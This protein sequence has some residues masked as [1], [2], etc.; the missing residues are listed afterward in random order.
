MKNYNWFFSG[1]SFFS[2][3]IG[4]LIGTSQSPVLGVFFTAIIGF[5]VALIGV[6]Q[7][8][9]KDVKNNKK[10]IDYAFIGKI[11][12]FFSIFFFIGNFSGSWYRSYIYNKV[13]NQDF[14]WNS[15]NQPTDIY[16]ALDWIRTT[17]ILKS[18]GFSLSQI[19]TLYNIEYREGELIDENTSPFYKIIYTEKE[20][21]K[22]NSMKFPFNANAVPFLSARHS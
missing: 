11:L 20:S 12:V 13:E 5:A 7:S 2:L 4:I 15:K 22:T 18:K 1:I 17:E 8:K 9:D 6:F 21:E 3:V 16:T 14:I 10:E 19:D